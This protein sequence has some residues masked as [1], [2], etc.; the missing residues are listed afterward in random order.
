MNGKVVG[1]APVRFTPGD[2]SPRLPVTGD[3]FGEG[4]YQCRIH[5]TIPRASTCVLARSSER[6]PRL[7]SLRRALSQ[8]LHLR[9]QSGLQ[10]FPTGQTSRY[11]TTVTPCAY[12]QLQFHSTLG[13]AF[14]PLERMTHAPAFRFTEQFDE[15]GTDYTRK[16]D[17]GLDPTPLLSWSPVPMICLTHH[18]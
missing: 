2:P 3:G 11:R 1:P 18:P 5:V 4:T 7:G 8:G 12:P 15:P 6:G 14:G 17:K 16:R 13:G 10:G 9:R